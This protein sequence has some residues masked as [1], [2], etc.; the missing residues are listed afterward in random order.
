[1]MK[2]VRSLLAHKKIILI[3]LLVLASCSSIFI[4]L[5]FK[6]KPIQKTQLTIVFVIDQFAYHYLHKIKPF[7]SGGIKTLMDN[8]I[9]YTQATHPHAVP[10]TACGHAAISTGTYAKHHGI[11]GNEWINEEGKSIKA[12]YDTPDR[13]AQ[14]TPDGGVRKD[15]GAS[16]K[17]LMVDNLSDSF[18]LSNPNKTEKRMVFSF[19]Y[20]ARSAIMMGGKMGKSFWF[21]ED[22]LGMTSSK[23]YF[24][25]L[26]S[27]LIKYNKEHAPKVGQKYLWKPVFEPK[28]DAYK[29][30]QIDSYAHTAI[31][32]L[33]ST[34]FNIT[35]PKSGGNES[36]EELFEKTPHADNFVFGAIKE[37][38]NNNFKGE[39][40]E[41][42]LLWYSM[43]SLDLA[44]H[45]FGP[46]SMEAI[47][48]V[49]QV[50]QRIKELLNFIAEKYP[51][52]NPLIAF[53]A[54]HGVMPIPEVL[55]DEGFK[56]PVRVDAKEMVRNLN[57]LA[58]K[59]FG[60]ENIIELSKPPQFFFNKK[61]FKALDKEK[62]H[63]LTQ[64]LAEEI[65]K[66]P[67]I[68]QVW[69]HYDLSKPLASSDF[70]GELF[71]SQFYKKRSPHL[72]CLTAPYHMLSKH[73]KGTS[74]DTPYLYDL[75]VP[76]IIWQKDVHTHKT[77]DDPVKVLLLPSTL[78]HLLNIQTPSTDEKQMLPGIHK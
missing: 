17:Q 36:P 23:A 27:W 20:K 1:M 44:G 54:D 68:K 21:D 70:Y 18:M 9:L 39:E 50:D 14:F 46:H 28:S 33:C 7:L 3:T 31:G 40:H 22:N 62:K 30:S 77:I 6:K 48:T 75:H 58:K 19:S 41:S 26:P 60:V 42:C 38:L 63:A 2:I 64:R 65:S 34:T 11:V 13:A 67:S 29:F 55:Q 12:T 5:H 45:Y 25:E 32:P 52:I 37:C 8:G 61:V 4:F 66:H 43:S 72:S 10:S 59:E 35:H 56:L 76:L 57:E 78:A 74:H 49:Y 15:L 53:T 73:P 69:T 71:A 51:N 24:N 16:S 47:D